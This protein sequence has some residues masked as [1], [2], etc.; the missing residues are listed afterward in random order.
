MKR[1]EIARALAGDAKLLMLDEP[2]GGLTHAEVDE[3]G[4]EIKQIR[5]DYGLT[6]LLVEH[7]M[8]MVMGISDKVVVLDF[9]RKIAEGTPPRGRHE[10]EGDR[11]VLGGAVTDTMLEVRGLT[12][13]YGP[14]EVLHGVEFEVKRGEVVVILGANGAGKT[15]TLRA[16]C[17]MIQTGGSIDAR[18]QGAERSEDQRD[19]RAPAWPTCRRAGAR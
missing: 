9:G 4:A 2:A 5:D 15:T 3:L 17:Q 10:P 11:G 8:A 6:I 18:R 19:R 16:L 1:V 13:R 12:A 7:H 14:I